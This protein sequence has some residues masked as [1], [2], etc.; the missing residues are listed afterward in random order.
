MDAESNSTLPTH[1]TLRAMFAPVR[2]AYEWS[3][4]ATPRRVRNAAALWA[5]Y[6]QAKRTKDPRIGGL[7]F[8][9]RISS[10]V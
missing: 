1:H 10:L 6:Q 9:I 8:S 2:D 3:R 4:K 7:P 5:S